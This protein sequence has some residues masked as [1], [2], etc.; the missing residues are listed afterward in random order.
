MIDI[1]IKY[2]GGKEKKPVS[3]QMSKMFV[4]IDALTICL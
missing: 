3:A 1:K 2:V 4:L